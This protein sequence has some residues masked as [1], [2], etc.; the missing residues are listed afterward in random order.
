LLLVLVTAIWGYTF[1]PVQKAVAIYPVFAFLAVRFAISTAVLAPFAWRPLQTL[2]RAGW[3]AGVGGGLLLGG[4]YG[5]QTA[6]LHLTTVS[7]TGLITGLYVVFAPLLAL[8]LFRT[9]VPAAAWAGMGLAVVGLVFLNGMPGGSL[10]GNALVLG[11]AVAQALQI[12]LMERYAP[13]Y[14]ARALT[15]IQMAVSCIGF[16]AVALSLGQLRMPHGGTVWYAIGVTGVFAGALGYLVATWIQARTTAARAA[17]AFTLE[18]PFAA[19][20]GVL[21]IGERLGWTGWTGCAVIL[22]GIALAEPAAADTLVRLVR[23]PEAV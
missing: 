6:G 11:T 4:A 2:P 15:C 17:L 12:A 14:D 9:A 3:L 1:V 20:F 13:R 18:A 7:S 10:A 23:R 16:T 19:L 21:L 22:A 8:G 5:L